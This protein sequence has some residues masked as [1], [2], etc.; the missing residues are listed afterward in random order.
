MKYLYFPGCS[1]KGTS[2]GYEESVVT[3]FSKLGIA[4]E[5]LPDWNCCGSTS[6]IAVNKILALALAARN[7]ALAEPSGLQLLTPCPSCWLELTKVNNV[8]K[9]GGKEAEK[10]KEALAAGGLSYKGTTVVRHLVEFLV[11]EVGVEKIK[12]YVSNQK[13]VGNP[14]TGLKIA[15]YYG[16]QMVRPYAEKDDAYNPQNMEKIIEALGAEVAPFELKTACCGGA[17]M[18]TRK[19]VALDM[20][21]QILR[22]TRETKAD[23]VVSA[24]PLCQLNLE[25]VQFRND[26]FAGK[27]ELPILSITQLVGLAMG[28]S[29]EELGLSRSVLPGVAKAITNMQK[30]K[31]PAAIGG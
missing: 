25:L 5:E 16:C 23:I 18:A 26:K 4:L 14:L 10:V 3:V 17:L 12:Q 19:N 7:L 21:R 9:E 2:R 28:I 20:G 24:C 31:A 15:P 6:V 22:S 27:D 13:Y 11:N 30:E 29:P 1:M 8:I